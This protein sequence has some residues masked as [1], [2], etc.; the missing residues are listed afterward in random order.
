[1]YLIFGLIIVVLIS[2]CAQQEVEIQP[3]VPEE[4]V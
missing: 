4:T 2:G 1:M 3:S